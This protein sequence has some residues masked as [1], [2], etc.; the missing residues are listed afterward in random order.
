MTNKIAMDTKGA[1]TA[2]PTSGQGFCGED[3]ALE[4]QNKTIKATDPVVLGQAKPSRPRRRRRVI[5]AAPK[6]SRRSTK[7]KR[8]RVGSV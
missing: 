7:P 2:A 5:A 4:L 3:A 6:K 8:C 1:T